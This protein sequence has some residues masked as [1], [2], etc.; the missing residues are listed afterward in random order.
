MRTAMRSPVVGVP[1]LLALLAAFMGFY[2]L[3]VWGSAS[4]SSLSDGGRIKGVVEWTHM[5]ASGAVLGHS[6]FD[7]TTMP[8]IK[9]DARTRLGTNATLADADLYNE[10]ALCSNDVSGLVCTLS[11]VNFIDEFNPQEGTV[12][13]GAAT[14]VY[15]VAATFAASGAVLIEELQLV[16][17]NNADNQ[18]PT[19]LEIGAWQNVSVTLATGD[20]LTVTWTITVSS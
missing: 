18:A 6:L 16:K 15:T 1:V 8:L 13:A 11:D 19:N 17:G 14:G 5:D 2:A 20:T 12:V 9:D 7:N 10:I 4:G 3:F